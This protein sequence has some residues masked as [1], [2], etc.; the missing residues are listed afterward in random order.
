MDAQSR[1]LIDDYVKPTY[2][3][4]CSSHT[5]GGVHDDVFEIGG[6]DGDAAEEIAGLCRVGNFEDLDTVP[7][8]GFVSI[9][10]AKAKL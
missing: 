8:T 1:L 9:I 3:R 6:V 7:E 2:W 10:E 5:H 4:G